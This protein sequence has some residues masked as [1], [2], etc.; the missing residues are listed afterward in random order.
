[1]PLKHKVTKIHKEFHFNNLY[2]V[3]LS[4]RI[5]KILLL[6]EVDSS[7]NKHKEIP[8]LIRKIV[9]LKKLWII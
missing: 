4:A 3:H 8:V 6:F 9:C 5:A 2:F 7:I 1:M